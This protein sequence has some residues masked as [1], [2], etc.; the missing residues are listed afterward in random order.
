MRQGGPSRAVQVSLHFGDKPVLLLDGLEIDPTGLPGPFVTEE[1]T[2]RQMSVIAPGG[3]VLRLVL[4]NPV[5]CFTVFGPDEFYKVLEVALDALHR[6]GAYDGSLCIAADWSAEAVAKLVPGIFAGGWRHV[7]I[8]GN[9]GL[10]ARYDLPDW[11]LEAYQPVVYMDADVVANARLRPL[12]ARLAASR[13]IHM[14][15][16]DRLF[17]HVAGRGADRIAEATEGWFGAWLFRGDPRLA[18]GSFALGSSG[19]IAA[20]HA[21]RLRPLCSLVRGLRRAVPPDLVA[22]YTDQALANYALH[23]LGG[24]DFK[25]LDRFVDFARAAE[26]APRE[27][28]GLMH[29]HSGVGQGAAKLAAMRRYVASLDETVSAVDRLPAAMAP[30]ARARAARNPPARSP[31]SAQQAG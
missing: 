18:D 17:T 10:F 3:R 15:T 29:F 13:R 24:S 30:S 1:A 28:R 8:T 6:F 7:R 26:T 16:E 22:R 31:V 23:A 12:L 19:I 20:D 21:G 5:I 9:D 27:R 11:A 4:Y 25:T 14:A 2:P